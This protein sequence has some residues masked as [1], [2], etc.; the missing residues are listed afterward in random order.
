MVPHYARTCKITE[1][2]ILKTFQHIKRDQSIVR[3]QVSIEH[4]TNLNERLDTIINVS[5]E[6]RCYIEFEEMH[7]TVQQLY[8][9]L[10][11]LITE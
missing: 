2:L 1:E 10:E 3:K 8:V 5:D 11:N 9:Q 7:W 4:L 6:R